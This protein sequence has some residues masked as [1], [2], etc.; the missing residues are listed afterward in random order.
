MAQHPR[1]HGSLSTLLWKPQ[2][3]HLIRCLFFFAFEWMKCSYLCLSLA[4]FGYRT[5]YLNMKIWCMGCLVRYIDTNITK[6]S[7][8]SL[9][10][11]DWLFYIVKY[12][13]L[14]LLPS[15]GLDTI[16]C[17]SPTKHSFRFST[18]LYYG[19]VS[20]NPNCQPEGTWYLTLSSDLL[21]TY[22]VWVTLPAARLLLS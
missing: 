12:S 10:M 9:Y 20:N 1:R 22:P 7:A 2:I 15:W 4:Q 6:Q 3:S 11:I 14:V 5:Y 17:D 8:N 21:N 19:G 18:W 16:D 13:S